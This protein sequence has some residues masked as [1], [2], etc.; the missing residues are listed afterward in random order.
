MSLEEIDGVMQGAAYMFS[1][2]VTEGEPTFEG[3]VVCAVSPT[4]ELVV[5]SIHDSGWG[6]GQN[7][8]SIVRLTPNGAWPLGIAEVKALPDGLRIIFTQ[9]VD[10]TAATNPS[11]YSIRSYRRVSTPAYGGN[12][13][14]EK[15]EP[16]LSA[17]LVAENTVDLKLH[18]LR[19]DSV[20]EV[21]VGKLA[22]KTLFPSEA[23]YTM[24]KGSQVN[25]YSGIFSTVSR[26]A[27]L[28]NAAPL[29]DLFDIV[30]GHR[31][32]A[33][34][35]PQVQDNFAKLIRHIHGGGCERFDVTADGDQEPVHRVGDPNGL[36]LDC[37]GNRLDQFLDRW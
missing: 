22:D 12:D 14:D 32:F 10:S 27:F 30:S 28:A 20:Y 24:K 13:Q 35:V 19:A 11:S 17:R 36:T 7:T 18:P 9:P 8:G 29:N 1:R 5:G 2:P 16:V 3:P 31:N 4:G 15:A 33:I 26:L 37:L 25:F 6:G 21:Q 34:V 23:H